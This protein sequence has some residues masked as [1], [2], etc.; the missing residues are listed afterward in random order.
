[1]AGMAVNFGAKEGARTAGAGMKMWQT[2][3][4]NPRASHSAM[5]GETVPIGERFSNGMDWPG[6]PE[7]GAEEVANCNCSLVFL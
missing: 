2:N 1:M 4:S 3:S 5:G 7:G 6:D